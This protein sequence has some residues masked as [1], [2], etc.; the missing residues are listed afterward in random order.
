MFMFSNNFKKALVG[1]IAVAAFSVT[2]MALSGNLNI[3]KAGGD[4]TMSSSI[5]NIAVST[6]DT[7]QI[8]DISS[9]EVSNQAPV[10]SQATSSSQVSSSSSEASSSKPSINGTINSDGLIVQAPTTTTAPNLLPDPNYSSPHGNAYP[11][12]KAGK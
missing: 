6:N 3:P 9:S 10:A 12:A 7:A 1:V 5:S 8:Q 2:A 11:D 4:S